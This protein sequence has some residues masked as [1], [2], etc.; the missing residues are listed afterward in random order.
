MH[1]MV[2]IVRVSR[3][4]P[5]LVPLSVILWLTGGCVPPRLLRLRMRM[6]ASGQRSQREGGSGAGDTERASTATGSHGNS[7]RELWALHSQ[8]VSALFDT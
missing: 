3:P 7:K 4:F 1:N 5:P 2:R 6:C 8:L